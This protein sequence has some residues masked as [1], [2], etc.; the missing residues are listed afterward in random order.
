VSWLPNNLSGLQDADGSVRFAYVHR[1]V[2]HRHIASHPCP[3]LFAPPPVPPYPLPCCPSPRL[4]L[5]P[6]R[7]TATL[8]LPRPIIMFYRLRRCIIRQLH[9]PLRCPSSVIPTNLARCCRHPPTFGYGPIRVYDRCIHRSSVHV[10]WYK[11]GSGK[12]E[13]L[14]KVLRSPADSGAVDTGADVLQAVWCRLRDRTLLA[15]LTVR[16]VEVSQAAICQRVMLTLVCNMASPDATLSLM[17]HSIEYTTHEHDGWT[18]PTASPRILPGWGY[19]DVPHCPRHL[20][21]H[22]FM[23]P[24]LR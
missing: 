3:V 24:V 17:T 23:L 15:V 7:A 9:T 14:H 11:E 5:S 8:R 10:T 21:A 22:T 1:L 18:I 19:P 20:R 6:E 12:P 13:I 16:G 4:F 2:D